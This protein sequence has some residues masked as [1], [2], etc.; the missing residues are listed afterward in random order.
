MGDIFSKQRYYIE[1]IWIDINVYRKT[2]LR[3]PNKEND[4][5]YNVSILF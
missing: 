2:G 4:L 3:Q 1:N 5:Q